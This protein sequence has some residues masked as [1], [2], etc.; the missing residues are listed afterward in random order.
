MT[1]TLNGRFMT[2]RQSLAKKKKKKICL[3]WISYGLIL[4]GAA[5]CIQGNRKVT[6]GSSPSSNYASVP[7]IMVAMTQLL[8]NL[9][10]VDLEA[11]RGII[12]PLSVL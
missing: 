8:E 1:H 12:S 2:K 5:T 7:K 3:V 9:Y 10:L 11:Y 4:L 6:S